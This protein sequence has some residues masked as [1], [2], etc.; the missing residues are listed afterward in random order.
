L[1]IVISER[2]NDPA[3]AERAVKAMECYITL[4][5][6][7]SYPGELAEVAATITNCLMRLHPS[8]QPFELVASL[9]DLR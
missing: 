4:L 3:V 6:H 1:L 8:A 5:K 9:K 7:G 2:P